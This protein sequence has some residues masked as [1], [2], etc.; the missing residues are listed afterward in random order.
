MK[1]FIFTLALVAAAFCAELDDVLKQSAADIENA[2][3]LQAKIDALDDETKALFDE[4]R[5]V[6]R[7]IEIQERYNAELE[8]LVAAQNAESESI[9]KQI[10]AVEETT[11]SA[12]PLISK[13]IEGFES[14]VAYDLPFL[15]TERA[16]RVAKLKA[17]TNRADASVAE[18][19]RIALEAYAIESEYSRTIEAYAGEL[20]DGRA[21][22][23]LRLGRIGL[24]YLTRD[25][26]EAARYDME[27][28]AFVPIDSAD[29]ESLIN[30]VKIA[31]KEKV[32]D[33]IALPLAAP[34]DKR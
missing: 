33:L 10:Y 18:K 30:A 17:L 3:A 4:Y 22:D 9:K 31:K 2:A 12:L 14:L 29:T 6:T 13:M 34:K 21:V 32:A 1:A 16:D 25:H 24:Y 27:R 28:K 23:F 26:S 11:R 8:K 15:P 19:Y 5:R 7:E 20:E